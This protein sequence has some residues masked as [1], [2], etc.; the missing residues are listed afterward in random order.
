M[1]GLADFYA[2][3]DAVGVTVALLLLSMSVA[4][5]VVIVWKAMVLRRAQR[6]SVHA[7]AAFWDA[8]SWEQ[9]RARLEALDRERIVL[10]LVLAA[11]QDAP[12]GTLLSQG[13]LATQLTRRLRD[14]LQASLATL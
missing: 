11:R 5:W 8:T 4:S 10:P 7:V 13:D 14:A 6:D 3:T 12:A 1:G 2:R 9:G